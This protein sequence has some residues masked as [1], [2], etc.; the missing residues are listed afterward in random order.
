MYEI[1]LSENSEGFY[2]LIEN[3]KITFDKREHAEDF[4]LKLLKETGRIGY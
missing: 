3:N 1:Y 4:L 2:L